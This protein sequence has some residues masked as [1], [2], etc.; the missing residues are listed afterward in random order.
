MRKQW[1]S[2]LAIAGLLATT[3]CSSQEPAAEAVS[4][5]KQV[6]LAVVKQEQAVKV[7]E[8]SGTLQPLEEA[9]VSFEVAGRI[10]EL[11]KNEGDTVKRGDILARLDGSDYSLQVASASAT[12]QQ[13]GATLEKVTKGAREQEIEQARLVVEK[14][15][16][17]HQQAEDDF[18]RIEVLYREKAISQSEYET[19]QNRVNVALTDLQNAQQALSLVTQGARAEDKTLSQASYHQA[20]IGKELAASTLAKTQ[21]RAPIDGTI[22]AKLG[23][24]GSLVGVGSPVYRIGQIDTLKVVLP[25]PDR[26]I[27]AWTEGEAITLELYGQKREGKVVKI[28]PA[29]NQSTGTIG[30]EVQV[31]NEKHDWFA[32]QV[33]KATKTVQGKAGLYVPVEA[34]ISRGQGEAHVFVESAGKAVKTPVTIGEINSN[35]LEI[36]SGLKEGDRLVVKGVDQL[37]DGDPIEAAGGQPQ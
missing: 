6:E 24:A 11:A 8:L 35:R 20:V 9:L 16:I 17:A 37:F 2:F 28:H 36:T 7:T 12:V 5:V 1:L 33:V 25:V 27:F 29:A 21:L 3:A 4:E 15:T 32:G 34:V 30:V 22:I 19:A 10:T 26:E 13:T 31:K 23:S 14:A 18:K